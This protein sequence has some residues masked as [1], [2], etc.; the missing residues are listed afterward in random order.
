MDHGDIGDCPVV[1]Q[2]I[3][4]VGGT[5]P[6]VLG[7]FQNGG[8]DPEH[9]ADLCHTVPVGAVDHNEHFAVPGDRR[10]DHGLDAERAA[11]LHEDRLVPVI[12]RY[13]RHIQKRL[14]N[15][16]HQIDKLPIARSEVAEHRLLDRL[17]GC[18]RSRRK[19]WFVFRGGD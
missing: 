1:S 11:A 5:G 18:Q 4:H 13:S 8:P 7:V 14:T 10:T 16:P 6:L 2:R 9:V 3:L 15:A 19:Q 12:A 17:A